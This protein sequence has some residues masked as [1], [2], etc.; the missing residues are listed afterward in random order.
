MVS[1]GSASGRRYP[2]RRFVVADRSMEPSLVDGQALVAVSWG[3]P[4]PGQL[5]VLAHPWHPGRWL[6]KRVTGVRADDTMLVGSDNA[7]A[8][9]ADSR[10]FGAVPVSGSYRVVLRLPRRMAG[11]AQATPDDR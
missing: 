10:E 2:L 8:T 4:R 6:V 11:D 9:R 3:R 1:T 5:R 7:G